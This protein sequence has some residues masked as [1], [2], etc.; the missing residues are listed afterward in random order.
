MAGFLYVAKDLEEDVHSVEA[1][2][3][4]AIDTF[5]AKGVSLKETIVR[6]RFIVFVFEKIYVATE[7][8][9]QLQLDNG[10]FVV[11][12]GLLI[13][14]RKTGRAA[15]QL[16]YN[17]FDVEKSNFTELHGHYGVLLQR[18]GEL[19][20]FND[21]N[22]TYL[23]YRNDANTI[24]STS[25]LVAIRAVPN[26]TISDQEL[27]EYLSE[28]GMYG[29]RT[30]IREV[31]RLNSEHIHQLLPT[32]RRIRK[33]IDVQEMDP[34]IPFE[35][36]VEIA[37]ET[38]LDYYRI[39]KAEFGDSVTTAL[40]GGFDSRCTV[41]AMRNVGLRPSLYVYGPPNSGDVRI[42]LAVSK[43]E[44]LG[45]E[46]FDKSSIPLVPPEQYV[47]AAKEYFHFS[48][49]LAVA[50]ALELPAELHTR[51]V[52]SQKA[53]LQVNSAVGEVYRNLWMLPPRG[54]SASSFLTS[55][56]DAIDFSVFTERFNKKRVF[57]ALAEKVKDTLEMKGWRIPRDRLEKLYVMM[58]VR[59]WISPNNSSNNLLSYS[60]MPFTEP[61]VTIPSYTIPM[62][63]K[64]LGR[65]ECAM[66]RKFDPALAKLP[67]IYGFN[68]YDPFPIKARLKEFVM[69]ETPAFA[70]PFL[71][72][73]ILYREAR[74]AK[75]L[76]LTPAYLSKMFAMKNLEIS[77]YVQMDKV[78]DLTVFNRALTAEFILSNRF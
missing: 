11:A 53:K 38:V 18:K 72:R 52:R 33:Q 16:L 8:I 34:K 21:Y 69:R 2:Y 36:Q 64:Y 29:D 30:C 73:R 48:D 15:L 65:F 19:Y 70:R 78:R 71:R 54:M 46:H 41:A 25:F 56:Y 13:Y 40:S 43:A 28:G 23:L 44:N 6:D 35:Q 51:R 75:L 31:A 66:M 49:G 32:G 4:S 9:L 58:R 50:G 62:P 27:Y 45:V 12:T 42:S 14:K 47:D 26:R 17:E 10:D 7:N 1:R 37:C 55:R 74:S 76:Q 3:R 68:F 5:L 24:L 20:A 39:I 57:G 63:Y 60:A 22:G 77:R 67:S 61:H 59:H